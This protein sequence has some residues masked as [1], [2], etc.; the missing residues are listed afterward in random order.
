MDY[1]RG[2]IYLIRNKNNE[3]LI[4]VGSTIEQYLSKRF[5][6]HKSHKNCSLYQYINNPDN[7]TNWKEFYIELYEEYPCEN[8]Q[9]LCKREYEIIREKATINKIGYLTEEM[10][11][12]YNKNYYQKNINKFNENNKKYHE[13]NKGRKKE[14]NKDY[15]EK[16]KEEIKIKV[17]EYQKENKEVIKDKKKIYREENKIEINCECGSCIFKYKLNDHLKKK[18]AY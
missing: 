15:Y 8:K 4:Y 18:K 2:K 11:K 6:K 3:N 12:E 10:R 13:E 7:N 5:N 16:N 17:K 1:L 14:I 9:Q